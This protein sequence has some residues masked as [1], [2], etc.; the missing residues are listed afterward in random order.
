MLEGQFVDNAF[1]FE[2][3]RYY[4]NPSSEFSMTLGGKSI[5]KYSL[6]ESDYPT[7]TLTDALKD[8]L[9]NVIPTGHYELAL[10]DM[11][12]CFILLQSKKP[13]AII[14]VFKVEDDLSQP[15]LEKNKKYKKIKKKQ[16]KERQK[17]N[18]KRDV[19]GMTEDVERI[20]MEASIEYV[21]DGDYFLIKYERGVTRAWGAIK[22]W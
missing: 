8:D 11:R 17:V 4:A 10:S 7:L 6:H 2:Q 3:L 14:P 12:D 21:E 22:S 19:L 13:L 16:N 5:Y 15:E 1:K 20:N 9:G 18:K